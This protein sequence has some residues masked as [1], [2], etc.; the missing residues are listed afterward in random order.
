M[1]ELVNFRY[2]GALIISIGTA[3]GVG[4]QQD[5]GIS[6]GFFYIH[7]FLLLLNIVNNNWKP[8]FQPLLLSKSC[9]EQIEEEGGNEEVESQLVNKGQGFRVSIMFWANLAK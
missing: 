6:D 7:N 9:I 8:S 3:V 2:V 1:Y 5:W 4:E